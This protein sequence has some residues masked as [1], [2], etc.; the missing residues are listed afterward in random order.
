MKM[1]FYAPM[2]SIIQE[3]LMN[4]INSHELKYRWFLG[5][6][7]VLHNIGE[8]AANVVEDYLRLIV[9][10]SESLFKYFTFVAR[11]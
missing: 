1:K 4:I 7:Y 3:W 9:P 8:D 5:Q 10:M 2:C 6:G 11:K